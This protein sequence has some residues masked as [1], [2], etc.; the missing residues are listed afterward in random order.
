MSNSID[1]SK[2]KL[3]EMIIRGSEY[4]EDYEFEL[5]GEDVTAII[6]PLVDDEFLPIAA[7]LAEKFDLEEEA[8]E[9][10]A[11]SE[12]IDKVEEARDEEADEIDMSEM[13]DEFVAIMQEAAVFGLEGTYDEDGE[14]VDISDE[15]ARSLVSGMMG[16]YSIEMGTRVLE[17]SGDVRDAEKFR[18]GRGSVSDNSDK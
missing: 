13:D 16:G 18:G 3:H 12:A 4:R 7:V 14:E 5:Y 17:V 15:E 11:V 10:K 2:S 8:E 6:R 1:R 9:E